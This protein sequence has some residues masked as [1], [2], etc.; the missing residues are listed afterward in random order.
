MSSVAHNKYNNVK[1]LRKIICTQKHFHTLD[2]N[3]RTELPFCV[4]SLDRPVLCTYHSTLVG[5][6]FKISNQITVLTWSLSGQ[7]CKPNLKF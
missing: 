2:I 3:A 6:I 4:Y 5:V 7:T 1:T